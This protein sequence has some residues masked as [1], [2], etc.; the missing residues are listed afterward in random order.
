[1][2]CDHMNS[3]YTEVICGEVWHTCLDCGEEFRDRY[4]D[5]QGG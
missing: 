4:Q 1:M 5:T 3:E 2:I